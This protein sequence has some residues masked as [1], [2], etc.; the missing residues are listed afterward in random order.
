MLMRPAR[1]TLR[2]TVGAVGAGSPSPAASGSID[3]GRDPLEELE[4][5]DRRHVADPL[6][7]TLEVV[8]GHPG[9]QLGLSLLD[10][11]EPTTVEQLRAHRLAQPLD[12][13][14]GG[15]RVGGGEEVADA[16]SQADAIERHGGGG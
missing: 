10:R 3:L 1:S 11:A 14:G 12:L 13:A 15:G 16:V 9:V 6:V 8:V 7:F 2:A 5:P 4:A